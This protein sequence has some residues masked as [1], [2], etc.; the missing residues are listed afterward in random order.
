MDE[1]DAD[2]DGIVDSR[3]LDLDGDGI[4]NPYDSDVD[5]DGVENVRIRTPMTHDSG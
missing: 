2:G 1:R 5:G 3:D 4:L